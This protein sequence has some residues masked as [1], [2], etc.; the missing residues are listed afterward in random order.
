MPCGEFF[1]VAML[2]VCSR[3]IF[4]AGLLKKFKD[5]YYPFF[6]IKFAKR[7]HKPYNPDNYDKNILQEQRD[8]YFVPFGLYTTGY[9]Q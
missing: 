5:S 3:N 7:E 2:R 6:L 8:I 4:V 1:V 9:I